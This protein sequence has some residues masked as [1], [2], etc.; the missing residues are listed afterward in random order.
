MFMFEMIFSFYDNVLFKDTVSLKLLT[1]VFTNIYHVSIGFCL[2][3]HNLLKCNN[4]FDVSD[5]THEVCEAL[6]LFGFTDFR[7]GQEESIMRVLC[8]ENVVSV[9]SW[10]LSVQIL[11]LI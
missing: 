11:M 2:Y 8:G 4:S 3:L 1:P 10:F 9:Y 6:R 7:Q 5:T